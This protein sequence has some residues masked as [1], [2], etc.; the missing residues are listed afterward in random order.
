MT[1]SYL[2]PLATVVSGLVA[3]T[4]ALVATRLAARTARH[5]AHSQ[6][7]I[8]AVSAFLDAIDGML[9]ARPTVA[10]MKEVTSALL[11]IELFFYGRP[12]GTAMAMHAT[13]QRALAN[14]PVPDPG[15]RTLTMLSTGAEMEDDPREATRYDDQL[16][17]IRKFRRSAD[18]AHAQGRA[19]PDGTHI[20][21]DLVGWLDMEEEEA[22][23]ALGSG[24]E[25]AD[26]RARQ[27]RLATLQAELT[28][29]RKQLVK[30]VA[31]WLDSPPR[32]PRKRKDQAAV[33]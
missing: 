12:V 22:V 7:R 14:T 32:R 29:A 20:I 21:A 33:A 8:E 4:V 6:P 10:G 19:E 23:A 5:T 18:E 11:R 26:R 24:Q 2:V 16:R 31:V 25:R 17:D 27:E 30:E 9:V 1:T 3:A 15:E 13:A 28:D